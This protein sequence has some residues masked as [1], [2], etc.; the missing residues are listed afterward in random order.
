MS[1]AIKR[2]YSPEES[3]DGYR[4]LIDRLWPRGIKK[5]KA[6]IDN[7][8]KEIGPST[9]LRKWFGHDPA[10]WES[11]KKKYQAELKDNEALSELR[12]IAQDHKKVTLL[13]GAKDEEHNHAV[14]LMK[15]LGSKR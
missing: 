12:K 1:I 4:V 8:L 13:Y 5:E 11:F 10:R 15:L 9:P 7:W 14:V 2:I 3:K 6:N